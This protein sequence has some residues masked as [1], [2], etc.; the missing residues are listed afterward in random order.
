MV[1]TDLSAYPNPAN[2]E[3]NIQLDTPESSEV[4][5]TAYTVTGAVL[6]QQEPIVTTAGSNRIALNTSTWAE[7][8]Y[9]VEVAVNGTKSVI[10]VIIAR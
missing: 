5:V 9:L 8:T 2:D 1:V 4:V 6:A 7:G 3:L 10:R